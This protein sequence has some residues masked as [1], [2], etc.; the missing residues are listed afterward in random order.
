MST[1]IPRN[2]RHVMG[3]SSLD[4]FNGDTGV[5]LLAL[6]SS[7]ESHLGSVMSGL[8]LYWPV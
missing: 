5:I 7:N 4:S 3:P 8:S 1:F 2:D 6:A